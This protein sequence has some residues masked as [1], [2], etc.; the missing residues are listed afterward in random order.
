MVQTARRVELHDTPVWKVP[1]PLAAFFRPVIEE[2][3][4]EPA[5]PAIKVRPPQMPPKGVPKI[6]EPVIYWRLNVGVAEHSCEPA[7]ADI[8]SYGPA[9]TLNLNIRELGFITYQTGVAYSKDPQPG[10]WCYTSD[11]K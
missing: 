9:Q 7:V 6:W 8:H 5:R 3:V 2:T 11:L 1:P 4:P 10:H